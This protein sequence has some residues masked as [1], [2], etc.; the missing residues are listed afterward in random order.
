MLFDDNLKL[1]VAD[2]YDVTSNHIK[3]SNTEW[4]AFV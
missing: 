1:V 3:I 2:Y 4:W